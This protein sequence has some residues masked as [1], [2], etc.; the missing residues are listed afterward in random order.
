MRFAVYLVENLRKYVMFQRGCLQKLVLL[1]LLILLLSMKLGLR[2]KVVIQVL[3]HLC[4]T[5]FQRKIVLIGELEVAL[6]FLRGQIINRRKLSSCTCKRRL[7]G[8]ASSTIYK[9]KWL[10]SSFESVAGLGSATP[11]IPMALKSVSKHFRC[12][13]NSIS[14]QLK[15]ISEALGEDLS[16]PTTSTCSKADT[17]MARLRCMD[18]SFLKNKSGR[19]T[20][21]LLEPQQHVWRPQRG[22]PE[23]AVAILKAWLF[24]HFLHPYPTDTDKHMLA[25][26]TG[27]SRNQVSNW[28][29]NARVRVWKPMVEEMHMLETKATGSKDKC[30][31]TEGTSSGTEGDTSQP[32]VDKPLS[33]SGKNSIPE[34]QFQSIEMGSSIAAIAEENGL[35]KEQWSQEKRSKLECQMTS[36]MDGTLMGFV[37]YRHGG[38]EVGGLGSVSLTLGL[39]HGVEGVQHQQQLQEE[40]LRHHLGGHMIRDF[41]G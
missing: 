27:L 31:K 32:R 26:Q 6:V 1:L 40:Q 3:R 29:I 13:K 41:V 33:N 22:L 37:P 2:Q 25:S 30:G 23:R 7:A 8:N 16:M 14:D 5:I 17:N 18:Q 9:C 21:D 11:Y 36:N 20:T 12:L 39:R 4:C 10:V 24:E 19:G 15:R 34:T 35:N 38:L 28:F